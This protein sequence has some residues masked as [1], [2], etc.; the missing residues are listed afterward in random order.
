ML[1]KDASDPA[2]LDRAELDALLEHQLVALEKLA[3][4]GERFS[5]ICDGDSILQAAA[6]IS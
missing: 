5:I 2:G 3:S 1:V 6:R 4:G